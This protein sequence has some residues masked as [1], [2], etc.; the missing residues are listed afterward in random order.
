VVWPRVGVGC[1]VRREAEVLLVRR[2]GSHGAGSWSSP[3]GNLDFGE[4]PAACAAREAAEDTGV[5]V[6]TPMF[7]GL[8]SDV[9][10]PEGKHYVTLWFEA[11]W[12]SGGASAVAEDELSEVR[13]FPEDRL[14]Q[15][16]FLPLQ[17]FLAGRFVR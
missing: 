16:L 5:A 4:D 2:R 9:F 14:P 13:W 6:G 12:V 1:I 10:A 11:E 3:G 8:T 15:P 17:N 7:V